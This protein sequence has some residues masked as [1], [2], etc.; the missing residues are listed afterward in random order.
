VADEKKF[1]IQLGHLC[2]N[3][4]VFCVS[5][6]LTKMGQ[7]PLLPHESVARRIADA[8]EA[9]HRSITLL[10]G[11]PTIQPFFLDIVKQCVALGFEEIV[12][13]SNGSK[14][15]RT[16]LI[17]RILETGGRFEWRFS[18]QGATRE[19]HERTTRRKGSWDQ[20]VRSLSLVRARDQRVT[21]NMCVVKQNFESIDRFP[22]LLLP[23]GVSQVHLDMV[24]PN[25]T[26]TATE[27]ELDG[28]IPRYSDLVAPLASMVN[29]LGD[30]LD[31]N[32]GNLPY[33]IAP[34][35]ASKIHHGGQPTSTV[36]VDDF[37]GEAMQVEKDKYAHKLDHKTKPDRCRQCVFDDRCRGVFDA[38]EKRY[39]LDELQPITPERLDPST[40]GLRLSVRNRLERLRSQAPFGCLRWTDVSVG[41]Q[42]RRVELMFRVPETDE[43]VV[44]WLAEQ[45]TKTSGGYRVDEGRTPS[46]ELVQG[47]RAILE[48]LGRMPSSAALVHEERRVE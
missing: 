37:G 23:N 15:A 2:N 11:E 45:N 8:R 13:F 32:I 26:G 41:D 27:D 19:A 16:D 43:R 9:G 7:A 35:L 28:I 1:E 36:T 4:C 5:G 17:D 31:V 6:Q 10:G 3:R 21:V 25:D 44:V 30:K 14:L 20:L 47:I 46:P 40:L 18:F 29:A 22:E 33:C 48:A 24:N 38:Y 34:S 42:G 12:I 39:G